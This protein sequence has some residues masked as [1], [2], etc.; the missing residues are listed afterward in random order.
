MPVRGCLVER[1]AAGNGHATVTLGAS[2]ERAR[3]G[4]VGPYIS[5][6]L[7]PAPERLLED[8]EVRGAHGSVAIWQ[9]VVYKG[10]RQYGELSPADR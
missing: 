2:D 6:L 3:P 4:L 7:V 10:G 9:M 1:S 8:W 5:S